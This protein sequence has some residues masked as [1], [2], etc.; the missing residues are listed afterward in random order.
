MRSKIKGTARTKAESAWRV[1]ARCAALAREADGHEE[2]EYYVKMRDA[3][4]GLGN[5]C[6]FFDLPDAR[7]AV[8]PTGRTPGGKAF[9]HPVN[10][11]LT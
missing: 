5:R 10:E 7:R 11:S 3:W 1:A 2:R 4:I 6:Q 9:R 8:A